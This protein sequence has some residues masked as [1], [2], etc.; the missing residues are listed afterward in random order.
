MHETGWTL[1]RT[2]LYKDLAKIE[3][4]Y[5]QATR[6]GGKYSRTTA[7]MLMD[8]LEEEGALKELF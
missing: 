7:E 3:S 5:R 4:D 1:N 8:M 6:F 2:K